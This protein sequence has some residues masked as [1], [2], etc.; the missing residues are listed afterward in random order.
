MLKFIGDPRRVYY[1]EDFSVIINF[2]YIAYQIKYSHIYL[3]GQLL[4]GRYVGGPGEAGQ[5]VQLKI[6]MEYHISTITWS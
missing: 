3:D 1:V 5:L 6:M 2:I 4:L